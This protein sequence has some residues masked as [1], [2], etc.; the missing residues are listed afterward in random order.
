MSIGLQFFES[1]LFPHYNALF[2]FLYTVGIDLYTI[3]WLGQKKVSQWNE[4]GEGMT[5]RRCD[6]AIRQLQKFPSRSV[7][8]IQLVQLLSVQYHFEEYAE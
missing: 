4:W 8:N 3:K 7:Y 6:I 2:E 5:P 1:L